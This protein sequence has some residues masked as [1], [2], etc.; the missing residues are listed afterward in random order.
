MGIHMDSRETSGQ[1]SPGYWKPAVATHD[2]IF[3]LFN[4][5]FFFSLFQP[6]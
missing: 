6:H 2:V 3:H 4:L 1:F 5:I